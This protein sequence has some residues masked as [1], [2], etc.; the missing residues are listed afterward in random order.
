VEDVLVRVGEFTFLVDFV[1]M[2]MDEDEKVLLILE[3]TFIF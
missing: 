2:E 3:R 1:V